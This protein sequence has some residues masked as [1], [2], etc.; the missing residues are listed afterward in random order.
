LIKDLNDDD[1]KWIFDFKKNEH[2]HITHLFFIRKSFETLIK[3]NHE[4][5]LMNCIYKT[6]RFKMSSLIIFD[7]TTLHINFYIVF[8]FLIKKI[9]S[10]YAWVL[11]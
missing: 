11:N 7:Q 1:E 10:D 2:D 8:V 4:V 5:I 9:F 3:S 6:N